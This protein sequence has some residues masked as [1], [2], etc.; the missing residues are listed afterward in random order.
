MCFKDYISERFTK[1]L[2]DIVKRKN[3]LLLIDSTLLPQFFKT[4]VLQVWQMIKKQSNVSVSFD[5]TI[6]LSH[7]FSAAAHSTCMI[8]RSSASSNHKSESAFPS[9]AWLSVKSWWS[10][11]S[12]WLSVKK[13]WSSSSA[14]P[15]VKSYEAR[16]QW[17][18]NSTEGIYHICVR[19]FLQTKQ[20]RFCL[21]RGEIQNV[22]ICSGF[23]VSGVMPIISTNRTVA[24]RLR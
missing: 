1:I 20:L 10:S 7:C 15:S 19:R 18:Q 13:W 3:S 21:V 5:T 9:S 22:S 24:R 16:L 4:L 17:S 2:E 11:P 12:A 8:N 23:Q 14:W 6:T